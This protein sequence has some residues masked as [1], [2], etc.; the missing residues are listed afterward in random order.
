MVFFAAEL[1]ELSVHLAACFLEHVSECCEHFGGKNLPAVFCHKDKMQNYFKYAGTTGSPLKY[2]I[3]VLDFVHASTLPY[4]FERRQV[5]MALTGVQF[6][7][8]PTPEQKK[9]LSQW[10]GCARFVWNAKCEE[11]SYLYHF[12]QRYLPVNTRT[13]VDQ[14]YAQFKCKELSPWLFECP[15]VLLRNT[16]ATWKDT[17]FKFLKGQCGRP[18]RKKKGDRD[19]VWL[20]SE[21]F[22]FSDGKLRIGGAKYNLGD[23]R[24]KAHRFFRAPKSLRIKR[25]HGKY[26][27]SFC[28]EAAA[29]LDEGTVTAKQHLR[30]LSGSNREELSAMVVGIDRGVKVAVH[31][32]VAA[33]NF[34]K[35]QERSQWNAKKKIQRHQRQLARQ[36]KGSNHRE[37]TKQK[38]SRAHEKIADIRKDFAHQTSHHLVQ[39]TNAKV[40]VFEDLKTKQMTR[41]PRAKKDDKGRWQKNGARAKAGLNKAILSVGWH[42]IAQYCAYK[43]QKEG[44]AF[45][46]ISAAYTSQECA[47]CSHIHPENRQSQADFVCGSCG[48]ADN[49]D[50]N[51]AKV[52]K[53]RAI[54]L[55]LDSGT[56]LSAKGVLLPGTHRAWSQRKPKAHR[57]VAI[58]DEASK[59]TGCLAC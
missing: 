17:Q 10:M 58:G 50:A 22:S 23:L 19:A 52:I 42:Q 56:E 46:K 38:I 6:R 20:P 14:S 39:K 7:A 5:D 48:N 43:A 12:K 49:A 47:D 53:K 33:Y 15:S 40:F 11:Q 1:D 2:V 31:S 37:Q 41:R 18:K 29:A 3:R 54:N 16:M 32:G 27:V 59:M 26:F 25:H 44:K 51:A 57:A 24:I 9:A 55:I 45:F 34:S 35:E 28:Y 8:Y 4:I 30:H 21:L 13:P 36:V